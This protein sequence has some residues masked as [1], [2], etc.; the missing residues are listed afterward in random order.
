MLCILATLLVLL[1]GKQP[2]LDTFTDNF[3][4]RE[5]E[6]FMIVAGCQSSL[7]FNEEEIRGNSKVMR[8]AMKG[9]KWVVYNYEG[10]GTR[11]RRPATFLCIIGTCCEEFLQIQDSRPN[12][13]RSAFF[14]ATG[15][16]LLSC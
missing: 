3:Y 9:V 1:P 10:A 14:G 13:T 15:D 2:G 7:Y 12:T 6:C 8:D 4:A 16:I 5:D 11:M